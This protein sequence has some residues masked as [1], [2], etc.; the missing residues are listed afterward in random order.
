VLTAILAVEER[1]KQHRIFVL[2]VHDPGTNFLRRA[3]W[4]GLLKGGK[5]LEGIDGVGPHVSVSCTK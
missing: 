5:D 1:L 2:A 4:A 3:W